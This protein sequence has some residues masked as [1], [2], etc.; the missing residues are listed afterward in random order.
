MYKFTVN[1]SLKFC[2]AFQ[3]VIS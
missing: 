2:I 3:F 1:K